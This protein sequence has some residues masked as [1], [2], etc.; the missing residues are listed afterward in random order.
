MESVESGESV[1][2]VEGVIMVVQYLLSGS[3]LAAVGVVLG[4]IMKALRGTRAML[5]AEIV[6]IYYRYID[7][8]A[9]PEYEYNS[10]V[11]LYA[12][13]KSLGGNGF[14]AKIYNEMIN[15]WKVTKR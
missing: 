6:G 1:E 2:N 5:R 11:D 9:M 7:A 10:L 15:T 8:A 4:F 12:Q 3:T 13:Y 14:V